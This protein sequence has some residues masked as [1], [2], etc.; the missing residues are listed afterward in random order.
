MFDFGVLIRGLNAVD[1]YATCSKLVARTRGAIIQRRPSV[2]QHYG[3]LTRTELT[4]LLND[5][6][7]RL[8]VCSDRYLPPFHPAKIAY[9]QRHS[10]YVTGWS[11]ARSATRRAARLRSL[12][13]WNPCSLYERHTAWLYT[14]IRRSNFQTR[15]N[16]L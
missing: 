15:R 8:L 11:H 13:V 16:A 2:R 9:S 1:L 10:C 12:S 6:S 3:M 4:R 5:L 7:S 14:H